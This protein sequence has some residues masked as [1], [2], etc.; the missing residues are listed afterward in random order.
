MS[1]NNIVSDF[2]KAPKTKFSCPESPHVLWHHD[3]IYKSCPMAYEQ[4]DMGACSTCPLRGEMKGKDGKNII[5]KTAIQ[6]KERNT[7]KEAT[8]KIGKTYTS[9]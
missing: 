8:P 9:K 3:L 5:K 7:K 2:P 6:E 1:K 4:R